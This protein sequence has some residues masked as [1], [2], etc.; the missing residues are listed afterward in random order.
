MHDR[1]KSM[2]WKLDW[3][4]ITVELVIGITR[5]HT[6]DRTP[7]NEFIPKKGIKKQSAIQNV[8]KWNGKKTSGLSRSISVE[9]KIE[10]LKTY[11][12]HNKN[13]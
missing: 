3:K 8:E 2:E 1:H 12:H 4:N 6:R 13:M 5:R 9:H 11:A 7:G 10:Q